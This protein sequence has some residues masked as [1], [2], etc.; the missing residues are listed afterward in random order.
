[1]TQSPCLTVELYRTR[2]R[3]IYKRTPILPAMLNRKLPP[4]LCSWATGLRRYKMHG[5][6]ANSIY[7]DTHIVLDFDWFD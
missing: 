4:T 3:Q 1:M 2:M 5:T 6:Y 7:N